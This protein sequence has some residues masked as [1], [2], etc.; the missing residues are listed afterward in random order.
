MKKE[1]FDMGF[2]RQWCAKQKLLLKKESIKT[3]EVPKFSEFS[4]ESLSEMFKDD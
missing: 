4:V 3:V 2:V 1:N